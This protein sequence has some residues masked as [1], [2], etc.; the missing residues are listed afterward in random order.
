MVTK[1][2]MFLPIHG[3]HPTEEVIAMQEATPALLPLVYSMNFDADYLSL[4]EVTL[5]KEAP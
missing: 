2:V 3:F 4:N 1:E 5:T